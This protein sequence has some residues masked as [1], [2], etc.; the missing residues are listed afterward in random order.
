MINQG[1]QSLLQAPEIDW[2]L[3]QR[4]CLLNYWQLFFFFSSFFVNF[5]LLLSVSVCAA[6]SP[7]GIRGSGELQ[8]SSP[9]LLPAPPG[10]GPAARRE[11]KE[12]DGKKK[13]SFSYVRCQQPVPSRAGY[14]PFPPEK[15]LWRSG[16]FSLRL[17]VVFSLLE[18][19]AILQLA[20]WHAHRAM[21]SC[22]HPLHSQLELLHGILERQKSLNVT[23]LWNFS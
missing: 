20:K 9:G 11:P 3:Q 15:F 19:L 13:N 1:V 7:Q 2:V 17:F 12:R 22:L 10:A 4:L 6:A 5:F 8:T 23:L 14:V 21:A 16:G 18:V